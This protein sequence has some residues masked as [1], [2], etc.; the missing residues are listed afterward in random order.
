M[1]ELTDPIA[2]AARDELPETW[3]ALL[4]ATSFGEDA[5]KRRLDTLMYRVFGAVLDTAE[6]DALSPLLI[7]FMG[8]RLALDLIIPGIDFW[9][10][11]ALSHSAGERE[12]K[13]YKDRA[14]DLKEL[15]KQILADT[16]AMLPEVEAELPQRPRRLTDTVQVLPA[17]FS[18]PHVTAD[19][20]G[21]PPMYG[22]PE[23]TTTG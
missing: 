17:G 15:R 13:A 4:E 6:Q 23:E 21:Y 14:E 20:F 3:N 11:Q 19:P 1:A 18:E 12:S 9:S 22:P 10:K 5:L 7:S 2:L 16:A 8:K